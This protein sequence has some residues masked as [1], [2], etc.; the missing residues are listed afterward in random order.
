MKHKNYSDETALPADIILGDDQTYAEFDNAVTSEIKRI[1]IVPV[2]GGKTER[3]AYSDRADTA[4]STVDDEALEPGFFLSDR[5]EIVSLVH[6]GGMGHVYKAIDH[7]RHVGGSE[8]RH[9]A[10]KMIRRSI[11]LRLDANLALER[12]AAKTQHLAHPNIVNVFDFD[13]HGDQFY[14]IMEWLEGESL[15]ALLRR[16]IGQRLEPQFAWRLVEGIAAGLQHAHASNVVHADV[17]P[18]NIFITETQEIKLLDFGV[19]RYGND[20][21]DDGQDATLWATRNY[22]SPEVLSGLTP[23]FEDDIFSLGCVAY[24]MMSGTHP[25]SGLS[26][27]EAR[28]VEA[29]VP[30]IAGLSESRWQTLS[31]ALSFDRSARPSSASDFITDV[32]AAPEPGS[33]WE[34]FSGSLPQWWLA[35]PIAAA[36]V[37]AGFWWSSQS[38]VDSEAAPA[39]EAPLVASGPPVS[40]EAAALSSEIEGLLSGATKATDEA[41]LV[42]QATTAVRGGDLETAMGALTIATET[43]PENPSI[44]IVNELIVAQGDGL[45]ATAQLAAADGDTDRTIEMLSEAERYGTIDIATID[46][47]KSRIEQTASA[48]SAAAEPASEVAAAEPAPVQVEPAESAPASEVGLAAQETPADGVSPADSLATTQGLPAIERQRQ[49]Q[50]QMMRPPVRLP[51]RRAPMWHRVPTAPTSTRRRNRVR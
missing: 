23:G 4:S 37:V 10:I 41:R 34:V 15:N 45:L 25:F 11:A 9:V 28:N 29:E 43:S 17:N 3:E 14:L 5:F 7:R 2:S 20:P 46:A 19:S 16:T 35:V 22:A 24:R 1:N 30:R 51:L 36:I 49:R 26:S 42:Q 6:S 38:R 8:Q 39:A 40:P 18:S 50:R 47:E 31:R 33:T 13:Q 48:Q 12:E 44:A 32:T 21:A 27:V